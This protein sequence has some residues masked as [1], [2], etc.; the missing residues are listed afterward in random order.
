MKQIRKFLQL[1]LADQLLLSQAMIVLALM[2]LGLKIRPWMTLQRTLLKLANRR[3]R[4][5]LAQ[6]PS[7]QRIAWA[8][9]VASW[10][11]PR[12][13]CLPQALAAQLLFIH[14]GYP[15]DLQIGAARNED[16]KFEAH[17]WVTSASGVVVGRLHDL[18]R[19]VPLAPIEKEV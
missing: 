3:A 15:A 2:T 8:I 7:A 13:A 6:R 19:F 11:V 9:R 16:G 4:F 18:D 10:Y 1:T 5:T 17:A 14:N 12:A